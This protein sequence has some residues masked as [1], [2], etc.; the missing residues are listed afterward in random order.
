MDKNTIKN[1][2]KNNKLLV[3]SISFCIL[4]TLSGGFDGFLVSLY[5][6]AIPLAAVYFYKFKKGYINTKYHHYILAVGLV[7]FIT[8]GITAKPID[9]SSNT[10]V[11][12]NLL[13]SESSLYKTQDEE[14]QKLKDLAEL[15]NKNIESLSELEF[16][17]NA[18]LI[19]FIDKINTQD[20]PE[21]INKV[22][23]EAREQNN[24]NQQESHPN[25]YFQLAKVIDVKDGSTIKVN[26]DDKE[27]DVKLSGIDTPNTNSDDET[28]FLGKESYDFTLSK[29]ANKNIWL[30][31][32]AI[33]AN[34]NKTIRSYVWLTLPIIPKNPTYEEVKNN[35]LNGM[36]LTEGYEKANSSISYANH[37]EWFTQMESDAKIAN[38][39][40]WN[41]SEKSSWEA[42]NPHIV[43]VKDGRN[44]N[45]SKQSIPRQNTKH[46]AIQNTPQNTQQ[47]IQKVVEQTVQPT[48]QE[49]VEEANLSPEERW[50]R[51]TAEVTSRGKTYIA[52]TTQEP[53]KGNINSGI[54]HV[55][56]Q[57]D[58]DKISV[59]NVIWFNT[60][61]DAKAAGFRIAER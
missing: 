56:G 13:S 46:T 61:E 55:M 18:E 58:Y 1:F 16:L 50:K 12:N 11:K 51:T 2:I 41:E 39:G 29:L 4:L 3:F 5:V 45:G 48:T 44:S 21:S 27:Y 26:I 9:N 22:V 47:S 25:N 34:N 49:V 40:L 23:S 20:T 19:N 36:L 15:R 8:L 57:K 17:T 28:E 54:Y 31:K 33:E 30:E 38:L 6:A 32:D 59:N 42:N 52:D 43:F 53:V 37:S 14:A 10:A 24:L 60:E 35:T 7:A